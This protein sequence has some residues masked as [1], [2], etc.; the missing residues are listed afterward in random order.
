MMGLLRPFRVRLLTLTALFV[1]SSL[2]GLLVPWPMKFLVDNVFGGH[3]WPAWLAASVRSLGQSRFAQVVAVALATL[4]IRLVT[5]GLNT[6]TVYRQV[7][8]NQRLVLDVRRRLFE[9]FQRLSLAFHERHSVGDT[10]YSLGED[11]YA[12]AS[13]LTEG[14]MPIVTAS[15]TLVVMFTVLFRIS[16]STSLAA[17]GVIPFLLFCIRYNTHYL[18]AHS[19]R[20]RE[21]ESDVYS[22]IHEAFSAIKLVVAFAR[23]REQQQRFE[24]RGETALQERLALTRR[25]ML[26]TVTLDLVLTAGT[27]VIITVGGYGVL[28]G[29]MTVGQLL[30]VIAYLASVYEP[31]HTISSTVGG[32][33]S[34]LAGI[35]RVRAVLERVPE[36]VEKPNASTLRPPLGTVVFDDVHFTYPDGDEV[37]HGLSFQVAPGETV[38]IVGPT[39]AGKSTILSLLLRFYDPEQGSVS[40]G[41]RDL[42]DLTLTSLRETIAVVTQDTLLVPG[43]IEENIRYGRMSATLPEVIAAAKMASADQFIADTPEGYQTVLGEGGAGLSGGQR[44]RIAI[45]RS[46]LKAAPLLLLDEPTSALDVTTEREVVAAW[47]ELMRGRTTVI[48][49]HRLSTVLEADRIIVVQDG[50]IV[51]EGTPHDLLAASGLFAQWHSIASADEPPA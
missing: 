46:F 18:A 45:A 15:I 1:L 34:A 11:A 23:E 21:K 24:G 39:G 36:V 51:E 13:L 32:L 10:L 14:I 7:E 42:R 35:R 49:A 3:P 20:V 22:A 33:Q 4:L 5:S 47:R 19:E 29:R 44:Q 9:Q 17:L 37:L 30:V 28:N 31:L 25:E 38:A 48:V 41:G 26:F 6:I 40:L 27:A 2:L 43:T 8:L 16:P 12:P 50:R